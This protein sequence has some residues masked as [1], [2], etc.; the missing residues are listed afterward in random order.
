V[1]PF[2]AIYF[3]VANVVF[4]NQFIHVYSKKYEGN[5][6]YL[7]IRMIR[8]SLDGLL[9]AQACLMGLC[10]VSDKEGLVGGL[11]AVM[12]VVLGIKLFLTRFCRAR[13]KI[14]EN[15]EA[16]ALCGAPLGLEVDRDGNVTQSHDTAGSE[17][18]DHIAEP[19]EARRHVFSSES[20]RFWT[21]RL[22]AA[23]V[24]FGYSTV[25]GK[26]GHHGTQA[27][28]RQPIPFGPTPRAPK[29]DS[30]PSSPH[31][32][33]SGGRNELD[34]PY[35]I[36]HPLGREGIGAQLPPPSGIPATSRHP[37]S[38]LV[39]LH[40]PRQPWDDRPRLDHPYDNPFYGKSIEDYL[41]L[42][43]NPCDIINLDDTIDLY[44]SLTTEARAGRLGE[45]NNG[46]GLL[47]PGLT[48]YDSPEEEQN[49]FV[50]PDE[51]SPIEQTHIELPED[52][53]A[54][55]A[56]R[57]EVE[58]PELR[59]GLYQ[60]KSSI[61]SINTRRPTSIN[62]S[63][64]SVSASAIP[65]RAS[66]VSTLSQGRSASATGI[67]Q[68]QR[69]SSLQVP[70]LAGGG[71]TGRPRANTRSS[72]GI[73]DAVVNEV[74]AEENIVQEDHQRQ[75]EEEE[76]QATAPKSFWT[77]WLYSRKPASTSTD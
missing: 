19:S 36:T 21:W 39:Q 33:R 72:L 69:L 1:L 17:M 53:A 42:P 38:Q 2:S 63:G 58:Q 64:R 60:R 50:S 40:P 29:L 70:T 68:T 28:K 51:L 57:D 27:T 31:P 45:W 32:Y 7:M 77:S 59:P 48:L 12:A 47:L 20:M 54:R 61:I 22:P 49:S 24:N 9:L 16:D 66:R 4:K 74:V 3:M 23:G 71:L 15:A 10:A 73:R 43:R 41:W 35:P 67:P 13:F 37:T 46:D 5:G 62:S 25:P 18:A 52:I 26:P 56:S 30:E 75:E 34:D 6:A 8:Y 65:R 11:A 76:R 44:Q 55:V 14:L